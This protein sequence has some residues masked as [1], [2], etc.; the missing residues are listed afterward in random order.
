MNGKLKKDKSWRFGSE[1][2][3]YVKEVLDSGFGSATMGGM[4]A[5]LEAAFAEKFGVKHAI[6]HNSG[7]STLHSCLA[8][9][10]VGPGDEVIVPSLGVMSTVYVVM[11]QYAVPVFC[12]VDPDTFVMDAKDVEKRITPY[13]KAIIP[14][15]LYGVPCDMDPIMELA[16]KHNLT[17]I[18]DNAQ[19]FLGYYKGRLAGTIG[20]MASF[21][22]EQ[23]KHMTTGDGG[24]VITDNDTFALNVRKFHGLGYSLIKAG[25]DRIRMHKDVYQNPNFQRHDGFGYNYRL[26]EFSAAIGLA[27]LA[28]LDDYVAIRRAISKMYDEAIE[29]CDYLIPQVTPS[30]CVNAYWTYAMKY[31]GEESLGVSWMDFRKKYI[32]L[33]GE[34]FYAAWYI[35]YLE[36]VFANLEPDSRWAPWNNGHYKGEIRG[37]PKGLTPV[38]ESIQPK[39]MQLKTNYGSLPFAQHMADA[40]RKTIEF[41]GK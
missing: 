27:Q 40:L 12:D 33:G 37:Y 10:G 21:S 39:I 23:T 29:D 13:T 1:E 35:C 41:Y 25:D 14:V 38:A 26:S 9:A 18:E 31:E 24:I 19:C 6:T 8:A 11:Q 22:F 3:A 28:R 34:G 17:V 32:E 20:H 30:D 2:L 16:E 7:T 15:A 5:R 36:P 4:N